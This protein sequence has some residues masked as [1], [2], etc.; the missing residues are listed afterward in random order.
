MAVLES[1]HEITP[2]SVLRH[3]P[4]EERALAV[5]TRAHVT[6]ATVPV[7][8]RASR[9]SRLTEEQE[10]VSEWKRIEHVEQK[11]ETKKLPAVTALPS[12]QLRIVE[13]TPARR[14]SRPEHIRTGDS[15]RKR[16]ADKKWFTPHAHP[17]LYLGLGMLGMLLL[18]TVLTMLLGWGNTLL[19][20]M[21]YGRPRTFQID[22]Y[23][24]HNEQSGIPSHFLAINLNRHIEVIELPGGDATH[25]RIYIGPQLYGN[26]DELVPVT[27]NF[28]DANGDGKKDMLIS[29]QGSRVVFINDQNGFRPLQ[30]GE[31]V[32]IERFLQR[33]KL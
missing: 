22:A 16:S 27:L 32:Q 20:D 5:G 7:V 13:R 30:A 24:G 33:L 8:S 2:K 21:R 26:G 1:I 19:N 11:S 3:R 23:V 15:V 14:I 9:P 17:L 29:F 4:I 12:R 18:W 10:L 31:R 28:I 6:S 25:A